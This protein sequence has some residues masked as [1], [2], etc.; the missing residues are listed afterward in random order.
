MPFK[1]K[2][3][4]RKNPQDTS[5]APK[6]YPQVI[7]RDKKD[8]K[9]LAQ[10]ISR[11]TTMGVGDVHGV[12]LSLEEEIVETLRDGSVVELGDIC[13]IYPAVKGTGVEKPED[14]KVSAHMKKRRIRIRP[15]QSLVA[16]MA[17]VQVQRVDA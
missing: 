2:L 4:P 13:M 3:I 15:K 8:L 7:T 6:H 5:A 10:R 14:F 1:F 12:L 16:K 17:G 11:N 9:A